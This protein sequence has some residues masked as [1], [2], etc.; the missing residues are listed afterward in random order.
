MSSTPR[1]AVIGSYAVGMTM[2][3]EAFPIG[4]ETVPGHDFVAVHGGKGSNQAVAARRAGAE[5]LYGGCVGNDSFGDG[6]VKLH[7]DEG[8]DARFL[9]RSRKGMS[10]GVGFVIVNAQGENEIVIDFAASNEFSPRDVD[11][12]L[13]ELK[14]CALLLM[15]LESDM[16]TVLYAAKK[17]G[18]N[19]IP[20]VLNPA[21][22][23]PLPEGLLGLCT[24]LTPNQTEARQLLGLSPDDPT[25]DEEIARRIHALGVKNVVMTLGSDGAMIVNDSICKRIPGIRVDAVDTTGAGDTFSAAFCV[26]LGEGKAPEEAIRFA[27]VAAG[28]AVTKYG[29]VESIPTREEID[30][31]IS[32]L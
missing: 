30:A 1:I 16:D 15:Q 13:P 22:F 11:D 18:E 24:Y 4:G 14:N 21:P 12:I 6:A 8:I 7:Q 2:M 26:A 25:D 19:G 31:Y 27:N 3:C 32:K 20:F 29:V 23:R 5:V 28:L 17:C 10:T 9:L